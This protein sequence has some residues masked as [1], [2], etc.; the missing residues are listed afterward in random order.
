MKEEKFEMKEKFSLWLDKF[1]GIAQKFSSFTAIKAITNGF[2]IAMPF[3]MVGSICTL[4]NS[5]PYDPYTKFLTDTGLNNLLNTANQFT[6]GIVALIV[7]FSVAYNFTIE[8]GQSNGVAAGFV[9]VCCFLISNPMVALENGSLT[10]NIS[11]LGSSNMFTGIIVGLL[12][13]LIFTY[14]VDRGFTIKMPE[15]VPPETMKAFLSLIPAFAVIII[16]SIIN[17]GF[18]MTSFGSVSNMITQL[19]QTP[20]MG[21]GGTV[22]T[23]MLFYLLSNAVWFAGI[24]GIVV[25]SVLEPILIT[26]DMQNVA[27]VEAGSAAVSIIGNNFKNVYAGMSGAGITIGLAILMMFFARSKRYKTVGKISLVPGLFCIN[28]P[29]IFGTPIMFNVVMIIPFICLPILSIALAYGLTSIGVLP[30]LSG[31]QLPWSTPCILLGFLLGGW[32]VA[33]YQIFLIGLS[34]LIYYPFFKKIDNQAYI[35][36][37]NV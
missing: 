37:T 12:S 20:L 18:G 19:I 7:A 23:L 22:W 21:F 5:I 17:Y 36:E 16:F 15:S 14:L 11:T 2:M 34:V 4:I 3:I 27:A 35:E 24:H 30:I 31:V 10:I 28:E 1:A 32:R 33:L 9:S 13:S 26:L 8:K 25:M 6:M 29:V